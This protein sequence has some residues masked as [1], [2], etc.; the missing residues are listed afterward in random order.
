[1]TEPRTF[2]ADEPL[3]D[4]ESE[5]RHSKLFVEECPLPAVKALAGSFAQLLAD[6]DAVRLAAAQHQENVDRA[7]VRC[8]YADDTL[9]TLVDETKEATLSGNEPTPLYK[10][11][12][13]GQ[14]PSEL[15]R[16]QLGAQLATMRKW[17]T[18]L[19][20]AGSA[21][22]A[23]LGS[24]VE[25][26]VAAGDAAAQALVVAE[27]KQGDFARGAYADFVAKCNA[28]RLAAYG[29]LREIAH[30]TSGLPAGFVDRFFLRGPSRKAPTIEQVERTVKQLSERLAKQQGL[31]AQL[32]QREEDA[33]KAQIDAELAE[34]QKRLAE[35][36]RRAEEA[37]RELAALEAEI[38]KKG[39]GG[40]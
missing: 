2:A 24:R 39:G 29:K 8:L 32:R 26:A 37:A 7:D 17:P 21:A 22:L 30:S 20:G 10:S 15:K 36:T 4:L 25:K 6:L 34:K 35:A 14:S 28:A 9:N 16:P 31:L 11:L 1:M 38:A 5:L 27:Q 40:K 23:D 13:E 19:A 12:F 3:D 18:L 33:R